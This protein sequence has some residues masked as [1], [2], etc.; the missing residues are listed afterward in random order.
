MDACLLLLC[1]ISFSV[2]KP[3]D[4]LGRTIC[5]THTVLV[6]FNVINE[7]DF[8][9]ANVKWTYRWTSV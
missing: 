1:L 3:R 6:L 7:S 4:W 9:G 5:M 2:T 8:V